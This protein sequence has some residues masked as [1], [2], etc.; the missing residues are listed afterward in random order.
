M[1]SGG[2]S[3]D[4]LAIGH[5]LRSQQTSQRTRSGEIPEYSMLPKREVHDR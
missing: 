3:V 5:Q 4:G 2:L 1:A